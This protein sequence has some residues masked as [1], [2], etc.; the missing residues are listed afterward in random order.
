MSDEGL[1]ICA[2]FRRS[3]IRWEDIADFGVYTLR[4][5]G[6]PVS[7]QVGINFV[8]GYPRS[9]KARRFATTLTGFEGALPDTYGYRAEELA[10]LLAQIHSQKLEAKHV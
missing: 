3:T 4:Q 8:E 7:R 5:H 10:K 2:L 6:L 9:L 1:E